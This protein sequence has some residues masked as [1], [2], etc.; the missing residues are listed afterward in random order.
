MERQP[1][2]DWL[3]GLMLVLMTMTHLP[4]WF[5]PH[6]G[7]PFGYV[8]AAEGFVFLSGLLVGR[9]Y[10]HKAHTHGV[11]VMR[12]ALL[13]RALKV[14]AAHV[15]LLL[16]LL[17]VFVPIAVSRDAHAITDLASYYLQRPHLALASGLVLAYNPPLLDILPM[18]VV[19]L[20]ASPA[21]LAFALRRG[22]GGLLT[23]SAIVWLA[24]QYDGGRH[25]YRA[26]AALTG[27]PVPYG[28][29]G[30]F[31]FAAWQFLWLIGMRIG[32]GGVTQASPARPRATA[33]LALALA[34]AIAGAF[35]AARHVFGQVPFAHDA[36]LAAL[37][38]KWHLGP[39][40][41]LNFAVLAVIVAHLRPALMVWARRSW[42][43][44]LGRAS[45]NVF[46]MQVL[47]CLAL[48]A[49]VGNG[50]SPDLHFGD[51]ALFL[52]TLALLYVTARASLGGGRI[53]RAGRRTLAA[54]FSAR[55]A[56]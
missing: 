6:A 49:L 26:L 28:A 51:V 44:T 25:V 54:R 41:L 50:S 24:A 33:R 22:W 34:V 27:W 1:E 4:T 3:R 32:A 14:Y 48:L 29:T 38:D 35:F 21:I 9:V 31:S 55:A 45:L 42:I 7:Q 23:V 8:S 40:R 52:G 2:I 47:V 56:R 43:A 12:R 20:L 13:G 10:A 30:A 37:F 36:A 5:G 46:S 17:L 53:F 39:L 16:S 11:A 19:F 15:A 18:Y